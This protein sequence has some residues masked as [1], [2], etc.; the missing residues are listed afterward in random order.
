MWS[1]SW[2]DYLLTDGYIRGFFVGQLVSWLIVLFLI[3]YLFLASPGPTRLTVRGPQRK[4]PLATTTATL[5]SSEKPSTSEAIDAILH[6]LGIDSRKEV[7]ESVGWLNLLL[8]RLLF[9]QL[10]EDEGILAKITAQLEETVASVAP[11]IVKNIYNFY[12]MY[13]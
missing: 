8:A 2:L 4:K 7:D 1:A 11:F 9:A 10:Q 13:F 6:R 12:F 3:R 5:S